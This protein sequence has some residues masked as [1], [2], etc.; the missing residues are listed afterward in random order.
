MALTIAMLIGKCHSLAFVLV[1]DIDSDLISEVLVT[2]TDTY[3]YLL[4]VL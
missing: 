2:N 4:L 3:S 1:T